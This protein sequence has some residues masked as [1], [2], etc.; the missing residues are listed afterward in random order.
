M[1]DRQEEGCGLAGARLGAPHEVPLGLHDG[2]G[3]LLDGRRL[4][5]SRL[6]DVLHEDVAK[7]CLLEGVDLLRRILTRNFGANFVK[8]ARGIGRR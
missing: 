2:D 6:L 5:V 1:E 8:S 7:V 3:V 4:L